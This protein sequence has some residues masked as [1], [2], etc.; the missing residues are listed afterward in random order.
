MK[1]RGM[2]RR[3]RRSSE[4]KRKVR[5]IGS[6]TGELRFLVPLLLF[7]LDFVDAWF[8]ILITLI[9]QASSLKLRS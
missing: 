3:E 2:S 7:P 4:G 9:S 5:G 8:S 6:E 1:K